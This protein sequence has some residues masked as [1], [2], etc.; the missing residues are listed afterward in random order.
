MVS[1]R[2]WADAKVVSLCCCVG[3]RGEYECECGADG[4]MLRG[5]T[6][7]MGSEE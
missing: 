5:R 7:P 4:G 2:R 3:D 1:G 6:R